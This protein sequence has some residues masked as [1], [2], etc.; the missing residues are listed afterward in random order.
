MHKVTEYTWTHAEITEI[1][2]SKIGTK[3]TCELELD[4]SFYGLTTEHDSVK[5]TVETEVLDLK[6]EV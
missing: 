5:L 6:L 2:K 1:L 3:K 4:L